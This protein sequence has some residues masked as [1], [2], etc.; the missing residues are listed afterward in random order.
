MES[1]NRKQALVWGSLLIFFGVVGLMEVYIDLTLWVWVAIL[2]AA[3]LAVFG[4]YLTDRSQWGLLIPAYVM[5]AVAGLVALITLNVLQ[6]EAI[7][8][9]VLTAIALPFLVVYIRNREQWWALI[10]AYVLLAVGLMVLLLESGILSDLLVPAYVMFSIAI[11]FLVV[12]ARNR[13]QW[14]ALIPSGILSIIGIAFLI[15]EAAVQ[16]IFPAILIVVG[17]VIL[18]RVFTRKELPEPEVVPSEPEDEEPPT[19]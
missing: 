19:E 1:Q 5:W 4:V 16:F 13:Q 10:P 2:V 17:I 15:A 3:G 7:A 6:D 8:A 18:V 12:Y 14:W 11:P 9:Y